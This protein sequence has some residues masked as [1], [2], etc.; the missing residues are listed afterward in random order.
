MSPCMHSHTR[1]STCVCK[2]THPNTGSQLVAGSLES[3]GRQAGE[4]PSRAHFC[5]LRSN[6]FCRQQMKGNARAM[7]SGK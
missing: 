7:N 2:H 3:G 5:L 4:A 6:V 1:M